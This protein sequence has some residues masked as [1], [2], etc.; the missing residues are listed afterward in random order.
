[1]MKAL[2]GKTKMKQAA[3][4]PMS[5]MTRPI[6]G[7]KSARMRVTK[8]HTSVCRTLRLRS[9][10]THTSTCSPWKRSHSPSMTALDSQHGNNE[11]QI[12]QFHDVRPLCLGYMTLYFD[13]MLPAAEMQNGIGGDDTDDDEGS[14]NSHCDI[15][16]GI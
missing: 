10:R 13:G 4:P 5:E 3:S 15:I 11:Y 16:R 14:C 12:S 7:M 9:R 1:M 8:N 2:P 6:S